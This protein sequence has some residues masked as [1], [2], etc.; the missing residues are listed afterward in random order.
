MK[1]VF[2]RGLDPIH[3]PESLAD[4]A[5]GVLID[6][7]MKLIHACVDCQ[8]LEDSVRRI[9]GGAVDVPSHHNLLE[10]HTSRSVVLIALFAR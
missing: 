7:D 6:A 5:I 4:A 2:A 3:H 1:M 9:W 10:V 8:G